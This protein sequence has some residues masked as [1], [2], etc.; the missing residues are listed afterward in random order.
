M[1]KALQL[2]A[3]SA[4]E[5]AML[6]QLYQAAGH[7]DKAVAAAKA[8]LDATPD[9]GDAHALLLVLLEAQ[10]DSEQ[11]VHLMLKTYKGWLTLDP[12]NTDAVQ[13]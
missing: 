4:E 8:L 7:A 11:D 12:T 3:A 13:G 10:P 5:A 6:V 1:Q 2:D 9:N